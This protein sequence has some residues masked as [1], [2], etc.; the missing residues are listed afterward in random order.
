MGWHYEPP[1]PDTEA[2]N[3]LSSYHERLRDA[4]ARDQLD[5]NRDAESPR[6]E[7]GLWNSLARLFARIVKPR[8]KPGGD[9]AP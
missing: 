8:T 3:M 9:Q 2:G 1:S 5:V 7:P 4:E 6:G